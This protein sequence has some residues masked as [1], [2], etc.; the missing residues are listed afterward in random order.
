MDSKK[1]IELPVAQNLGETSILPVSINMGSFWQTFK[2]SISALKTYILSA[3]RQVPTSAGGSYK[4]LQ[5]IDGGDYQWSSPYN[6]LDSVNVEDGPL[7]ARQGKVL[8]DGKLDKPH[9]LSVNG[10]SG[11][12]NGYLN[13]I[14]ILTGNDRMFDLQLN[15]S[16]PGTIVLIKNNNSVNTSIFGGTTIDGVNVDLD[17]GTPLVLSGAYDKIKLIN[18]TSGWL[19]I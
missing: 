8:N 15:I 3:A 4:Y 16:T 17:S 11:V 12:Q 2:L 14:V 5:L 6:A 7:D 10:D 1:I 9:V 19:T 18:T 13:Q